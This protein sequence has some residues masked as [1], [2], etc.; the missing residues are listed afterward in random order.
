MTEKQLIIVLLSKTTLFEY[1]SGCCLSFIQ[2]ECCNTMAS[3]VELKTA[4]TF[5]FM[6]SKRHT[7]E[8]QPPC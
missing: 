2:S 7:A 6:P 1:A 3:S 4:L 8:Q 5:A